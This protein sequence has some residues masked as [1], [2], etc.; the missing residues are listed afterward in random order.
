MIL[1]LETY[2]VW[3]KKEEENPGVKQYVENIACFQ[4]N[5]DVW[6]KHNLLRY[7]YKNDLMLQLSRNLLLL[8]PWPNM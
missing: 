2:S 3:Y 1:K 4:P 6:F 8:R 5:N 7:V